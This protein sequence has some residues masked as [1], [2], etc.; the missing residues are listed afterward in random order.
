MCVCVSFYVFIYHHLSMCSIVFHSSVCIAASQIA[1]VAG[2]SE[3]K[4]AT[5]PE[6]ASALYQ[7]DQLGTR[8]SPK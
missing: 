3:R 6:A 7:D 1:S 5:Y 4:P 2:S 8:A